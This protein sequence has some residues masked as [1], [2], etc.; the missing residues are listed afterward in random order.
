M[1]LTNKLSGEEQVKAIELYSKGLGLNAVAIAM[2]CKVNVIER[3]IRSKGLIRGR[4]EGLRLARTNEVLE[5][6][7]GR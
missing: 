3:L 7:N 2:K 6:R 5:A 1:K 4:V